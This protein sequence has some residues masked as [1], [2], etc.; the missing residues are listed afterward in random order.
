MATGLR[1]I[2][3]EHSLTRVARLWYIAAA[4]SLACGGCDTT[5]ESSFRGAAVP[6][7]DEADAESGGNEADS[8]AIAPDG[9]GKPGAEDSQIATDPDIALG[10]ASEP[11]DA[12]GASD[13]AAAS[14]SGDSNEPTDTSELGNL[15]VSGDAVWS[16]TDAI[17]EDSEG[18]DAATPAPCVPLQGDC[19]G[20]EYAKSLTAYPIVL[21]HGAAGFENVGPLQ[22]WHNVEDVLQKKGYDV[23]IAV[24]DPFNSSEVRGPQLA[25]FIDKVVECT[26]R[27]KVNI[28]AHSQG[29]LDARYAISSLGL[30]D[31]VASLTTLGTPH[32]GS[33]LADLALGLTPGAAGDA[34]N[35]FLWL[36]GE[37]YANPLEVA[38]FVAALEQF[39]GP[40]AEAFNAANPDSAQVQY[41]SWAG[42]P[43][44][45]ADGL[46]ECEGA[47]TPNPSAKGTVQSMFV[48][49]YTLLG[50]LSGDDNDGL[51]PVNSAKWGRFRGC[52]P[53]DHLRQIGFWFGLTPGFDH[54]D[55]F[56]DLAAFLKAEGF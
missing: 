49:G 43:G 47:E 56:L 16:G 7:G 12:A 39:S 37:A 27:P 34:L 41:Y 17:G 28:V 35:L 46:P 1:P 54:E 9:P 19:A 15:D 33:P 55:F 13:A 26:C 10:D 25:A 36:A 29:G 21:A 5:G 4:A 32:R 3:P 51:V 40:G 38:D 18:G 23:H 2:F 50:G 42:R 31:K 44:L 24:V 30:S 8:G 45:F 11:A 22:Y 6:F 52:L 48:A 20:I 14:D 53:A